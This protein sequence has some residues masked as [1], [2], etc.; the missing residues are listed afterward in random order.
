[1]EHRI[2]ILTSAKLIISKD[3]TQKRCLKTEKLYADITMADC[4]ALA[5]GKIAVVFIL[6]TFCIVRALKI[7]TKQNKKHTHSK[8]YCGIE[9]CR[10]CFYPFVN[11]I[12]NFIKLYLS[13]NICI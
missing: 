1:M 4:L 6:I 3:E 10:A 9:T 12:E 7:K 11:V 8:T 13:K 5:V 2:G